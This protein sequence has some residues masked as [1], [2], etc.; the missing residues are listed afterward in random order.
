[1]LDLLLGSLTGLV[2]P[3]PAGARVISSHTVRLGQVRL[4]MGEMSWGETSWGE[5]SFREKCHRGEN[6]HR[7]KCYI[8]RNVMGRNVMGRNV[9]G[10]K[11]LW[12]ET[13]WNQFDIVSKMSPLFYLVK[14][15][16]IY[17]CY[18]CIA[19]IFLHQV[20]SNG[21]LIKEVIPK[22]SSAI[23]IIV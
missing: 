16:K 3:P 4:E 21:K 19:V 22:F 5:M 7:E 10:E 18:N 13:P 8:G 1:M 11:H 23:Y 14:C 12:G 15:G 6:Y 9:I 2:P 17:N 20:I